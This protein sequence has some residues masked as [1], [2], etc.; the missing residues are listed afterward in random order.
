[1]RGQDLLHKSFHYKTGVIKI[2][3]ANTLKHELAKFLLSWEAIQ[4][5]HEVVTE[6]IFL[7]GKRADVLLLDVPEALEVV[8]TESEKSIIKKGKDYP[9]KVSAFRSQSVI[10][11][12]L[13]ELKEETK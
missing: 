10:N 3:K 12:Y 7:N 4:N 8:H 9:V 1:V 11:H 13:K 5:G 6:A 2:N